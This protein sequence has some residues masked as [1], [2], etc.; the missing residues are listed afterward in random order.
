MSC[1]P[2]DFEAIRSRYSLAQRCQE[3]GIKLH[4]NGAPG[5]MVGLCPFHSETTPSFYVYANEGRFHC[6]GCG[7]HGDIV[8]LERELRGGT[9]REAAARVLGLTP[10]PYP[11]QIEKPNSEVEALKLDGLKPCSLR[12]LKR[13]SSMRSIPI[14]GL[15]LASERGVLFICDYPYQ[16]PCWVI[17]DDARRNANARRLDGQRFE[18]IGGREGPKAK[19][20]K[21]SEA[22]WP[23]GIAQASGFP[24][25]ALCEGAPDL[26]SA[27][28]LAY[29]G[30]VEHLITP[31]CMSGAACSIHSEAL[32]L[33][34][35]KI[36]RIFGHADEAGRTAM[37]RWADQLRTVDAEVDG[38]DFRGLFK[39][40]GSPAKDLN[41]LLLANTASSGC[42]IET[43][44]AV[45]DFALEGQLQ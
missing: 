8:D 26:L 6:F 7:A 31:V 14:E 20:F 19:S 34:R 40:D 1:E 41:D 32:P 24:A 44:A 4:R 33:F 3:L 11:I 15:R 25:I 30:G 45:M 21:R 23:I 39:P 38:F 9:A 37:Q 10:R 13:I 43:V 12:Q 29:A 35:G 36:V 42:L 5:R 17:T 16:G 27:F 18:L 22:S 2:I 28:Y